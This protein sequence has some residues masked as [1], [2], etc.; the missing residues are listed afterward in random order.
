MDEGKNEIKK[1]VKEK[2]KKFGKLVRWMKVKLRE[3]LC[4]WINVKELRVF[5]E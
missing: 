1:I 5:V 3:C 2:K 4:D